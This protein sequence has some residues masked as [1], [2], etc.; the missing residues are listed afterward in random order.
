[1]QKQPGGHRGTTGR[2]RPFAWTRWRPQ[3]ETRLARRERRFRRARD[4]RR[5]SC[6]HRPGGAAL[7][8]WGR[9]T[10]GIIP[11]SPTKGSRAGGL[12]P[13][14]ASLQRLPLAE[15]RI[16]L[17]SGIHAGYAAFSV[18]SVRRLGSPTAVGPFAE[19]KPVKLAEA[20]GNVAAEHQ[21]SA[22]ERDRRVAVA[23]D[24]G[25]RIGQSSLLSRLE[26]NHEQGVWLPFARGIRDHKTV[27]VR[28]PSEDVG[29]PDVDRRARPDLGQFTFRPAQRGDQPQLALAG[30]WRRLT[31]EEGDP[32]A[33]G[34]PDG[35]VSLRGS[36]VSRNGEP[37]PIC[38]T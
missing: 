31:A 13:G 4:S 19:R 30:A 12:S 10:T 28:T 11:S 23:K 22:V 6:E 14:T 36:V 34:R 1:M 33:V 32:A 35:I 38:C 26:R 2:C 21:R 7:P 27:A 15:K 3:A 25:L 5:R 20:S 9:E 17:P 18:A 8:G 16:S 24:R 37:E 29:V